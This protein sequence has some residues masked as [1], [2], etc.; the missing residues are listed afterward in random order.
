MRIRRSL[1]ATIVASLG[2]ATT[3]RAD[4]I[5]YSIWGTA[6]GQIGATIFSNSLVTISLTGN[7]TGVVSMLG[8]FANPGTTTVNIAGVGTA[9]ITDLTAIYASP[10]PNSI[11]GLGTFPFVFIGTLDN[12]PAI[13]DAT[14][15]GAILSNSLL[16]YDLKSAFGP[17]TAS[18]AGV[19]RPT[20]QIV[21]TTLGTLSFTSDVSPT[22]TG[23]FQAVITTTP[24][25]SSFAL[26]LTG[27][28]LLIGVRTRRRAAPAS[29]Q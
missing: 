25:P 4:I 13:D 1:L 15:I 7:T 9:T 28:A 23:T 26:L 27:G 11:P 12:P 20:G 6:S 2:L 22:S 16:G 29:S 14:G 10:T 17:L 3:A 8:A 21:H 24:E 18:P 19:G 5:T